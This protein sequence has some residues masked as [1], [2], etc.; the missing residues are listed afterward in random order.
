M[1]LRKPPFLWFDRIDVK[2]V[3]TLPAFSSLSPI[4]YQYSSGTLCSSISLNTSFSNLS[5]NCFFDFSS[6][7]IFCWWFLLSYSIQFF[8]PNFYINLA[9]SSFILSSP[10]SCILL[11]YPFF[12]FSISSA[13]IPSSSLDWLVLIDWVYCWVTDWAYLAFKASDKYEAIYS[14][15]L[16]LFAIFV[17]INIYLFKRSIILF[18]FWINNF[19]YVILCF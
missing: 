10:N 13:V 15:S 5:S 17:I 19:V 11:R 7:G 4:N 18:I 1:L 6:V 2:Y 12:L 14:I 3:L 9:Y 16:S 8:T